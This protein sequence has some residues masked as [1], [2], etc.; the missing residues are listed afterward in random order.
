MK[1]RKFFVLTGLLTACSTASVNEPNRS[2]SSAHTM[3]NHATLA[4]I[5]E[6]ADPRREA[7]AYVER[8]LVI[9][10]RSSG[11]LAETDH[12]FEHA[13][14]PVDLFSQPSYIKLLVSH[15]F[16]DHAQQKIVDL[17]TEAHRL[18][19]METSSQRSH[20]RAAKASLILAGVHDALLHAR[21]NVAE[22]VLL[23]DLSRAILE[24]GHKA[25]PSAPIH[26]VVVPLEGEELYA[27]AE[28]S[29]EQLQQM[30]AELP[31]SDE[32]KDEIEDAAA[33][34]AHDFSDTGGREPQSAAVFPTAAR[35]GNIDGF[36]FP[37]GTWAITFDDGPNPQITEQDLANIAAT[38]T[39]A[40]FFWL[41]K[42]VELYPDV[43]KKV[44]AAGYPVEDHSW[45]HPKLN[46]PKDLARLNTNLDR[47][48]NQSFALDLKVYGV[49]PRFF[50]CPYG[51][52]F[53]DP[54]IRGMIAKLGMIHVR[55]NVDSL[56]WKDPS[57]ASV[58]KR[59]EQQ[60]AVNGQ[61]I[62][63][64]HDIHTP[65]LTVV[66]NLVKKYK[67]KVRWVNIPQ[68]VDELN[69]GPKQHP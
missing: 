4:E 29:A 15:P 37:H 24:A 38:N 40:T 28:D 9:E 65:A 2:P 21:H 39:K 16:A 1:S 18:T 12:I 19:L 66:P 32:V 13:A 3:G 62:I 59:V 64:F 26:P 61:G 57:P 50:R 33:Q 23:N 47:E 6:S 17:Y 11:W 49:K 55:W 58:Q 30:V 54:V 69:G 42:N 46:D 27:A 10:L 5:C 34:L 20:E 44:Q 63:L 14:A 7:R 68:I 53:N 43:V 36:T 25:N 8:L 48:I 45:S 67:G 56:D 22:R 51:A 52:G 31:Y 35:A 60:M 41:A